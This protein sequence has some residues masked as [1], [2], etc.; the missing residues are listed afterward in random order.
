[1]KTI[2]LTYLMS[3]PKD[4]LDVMDMRA[5]DYV[6]NRFALMAEGDTELVHA[7]YEMDLHPDSFEL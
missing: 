6:W 2:D 5:Y 4:I 3:F 1:M 7:S